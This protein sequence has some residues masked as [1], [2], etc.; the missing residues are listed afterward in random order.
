MPLLLLYWSRE[1]EDT[2]WVATGVKKSC[3]Q[4]QIREDL[5]EGSVNNNTY[6]P[7]LQRLQVDF[8]GL[9]GC[10]YLIQDAGDLCG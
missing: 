7:F 9:L 2:V 1:C 10:I 8:I 6:L 4:T 3:G 5:T